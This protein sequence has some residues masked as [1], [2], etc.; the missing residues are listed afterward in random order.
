MTYWKYDPRPD[1]ERDSERWQKLLKI[2]DNDE[3]QWNLHGFR[4]HGTLIIPYKD[5]YR[6]MPVIGDNGWDSK[7]HFKQVANKWLDKQEVSEWLNKI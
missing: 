5:K 7:E 1:L 6:L 2:I 4:C 3:L